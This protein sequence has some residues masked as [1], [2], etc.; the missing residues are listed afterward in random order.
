VYVL[1]ST[2]DTLGLEY[3]LFVV[4]GVDLEVINDQGILFAAALSAVTF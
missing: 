1:V 4:L 2:E 3:T